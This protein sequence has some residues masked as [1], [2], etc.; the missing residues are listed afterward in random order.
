MRD[1]GGSWGRKGTERQQDNGP[2]TVEV[3][4]YR[5][6]KES[7]QGFEGVHTGMGKEKAEGAPWLVDAL[8]ARLRQFSQSRLGPRNRG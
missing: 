8:A 1:G 7:I 6:L 5:D 2:G 4:S 3:Y